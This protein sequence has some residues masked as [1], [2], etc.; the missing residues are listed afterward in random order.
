M[1][2]SSC[3]YVSSGNFSICNPLNF[4]HNQRFKK[5]LEILNV[6]MTIIHLY[7]KNFQFFFLLFCDRII[8]DLLFFYF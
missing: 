8:Q 3:R 7:I 6:N 1:L 2:M 4:I 5:E